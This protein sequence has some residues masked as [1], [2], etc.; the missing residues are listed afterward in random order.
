MF[1]NFIYFL[2]DLNITSIIYLM[3]VNPE[4]TEKTTP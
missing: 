1:V 3:L 2:S 4:E